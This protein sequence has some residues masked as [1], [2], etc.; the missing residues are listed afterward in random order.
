MT[1]EWYGTVNKMPEDIL[2]ERLQAARATTIEIEREVQRRS[3]FTFA[4]ILA[5]RIHSIIHKREDCDYHYS[6]WPN[7]KGCRLETLGRATRIVGLDIEGEK[8]DGLLKILE[9][10]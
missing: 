7:P 5:D 6:D 9:E 4:E 10:R 2:Q 3:R 8:L 1:T